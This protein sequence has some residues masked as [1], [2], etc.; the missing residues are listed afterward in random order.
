MDPKWV[1]EFWNDKTPNTTHEFRIISFPSF[2][3][4]SR[5]LSTKV[6]PE[7]QNKKSSLLRAA[8]S[9]SC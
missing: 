3:N 4:I 5:L 6:L 2:R 8:F 1:N 7:E 9:W